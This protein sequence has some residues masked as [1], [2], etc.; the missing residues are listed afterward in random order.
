MLN[1]N[2]R[3]LHHVCI[4]VH[5]IEKTISYYESIGIGPW[6]DYPP[7]T[8]FTDL[9]VPN[10]EAFGQ[11]IYKWIDLDNIQIQLLQPSKL[12]NQQRRFLETHGEGVFHL[13]FEV[14]DCDAGEAAAKAEGMS[15]L[16]SGRRPDRSGF[17][18]FDTAGEAGGVVLE[19][20]AS[21]PGHPKS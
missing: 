9:N 3:K 17:T 14:P 15:V 11:A 20:R 12:D 1:N 13:G 21:P 19:I 8:Q 4:V 18:Y 16:M 7:L 10:V 2:F 5:D 6:K